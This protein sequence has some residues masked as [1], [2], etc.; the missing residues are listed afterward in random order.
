MQVRLAP[1]RRYL[2]SAIWDLLFGICYLGSAIW[3]LLFG[4]CYLGSAIWDLL[5]GIWGMFQKTD[6]INTR[7]S[8]SS[9]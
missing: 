3:D 2:G 1:F 6:W 4:I 8:L 9:Y 7:G 5:F